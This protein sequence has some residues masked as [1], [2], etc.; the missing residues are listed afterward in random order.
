[1]IRHMMCSDICV[2]KPVQFGSIKRRQSYFDHSHQIIASGK[3]SFWWTDFWRRSCLDTRCCFSD[4]LGFGGSALTIWCWLYQVMFLPGSALMLNPSNNFERRHIFVCF[5]SVSP[6][7]T[8]YC[9]Q[10]VPDC[11]ITRKNLQSTVKSDVRCLGSWQILFPKVDE[12]NFW[13]KVTFVV[14]LSWKIPQVALRNSKRTSTRKFQQQLHKPFHLFRQM[15]WNWGNWPKIVELENKTT[16]FQF[17]TVWLE[18][19]WIWPW[20][21]VSL[22]HPIRR[23]DSCGHEFL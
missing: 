20:P 21:S 17:F 19:P 1:M 18:W 23:I 14:V 6:F 7:W 15:Q 12:I 10:T 3:D 16:K 4:S 13:P 22:F 11:P 8:L 9:T 5:D 2:N